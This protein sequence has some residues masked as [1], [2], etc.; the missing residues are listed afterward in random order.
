MVNISKLDDGPLVIRSKNDLDQLS[1]RLGETPDAGIVDRVRDVHQTER[2][3]GPF[4]AG[5]V[6][7]GFLLRTVGLGRGRL[8][9]F[10]ARDDTGRSSLSTLGGRK[11]HVERS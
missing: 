6:L 5:R 9:F 10:N 2:A 8:G 7:A 4:A 11:L 1:V 3:C